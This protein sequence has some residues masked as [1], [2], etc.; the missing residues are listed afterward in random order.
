V[1]FPATKVKKEHVG[2]ERY[3]QRHQGT[4]NLQKEIYS[5]LN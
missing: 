3:E 1:I 4:Q 5:G 2:A